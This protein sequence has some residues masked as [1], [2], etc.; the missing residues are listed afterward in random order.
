M[1]KIVLNALL[2]SAVAFTA[3]KNDKSNETQP[4][5]AQEVAMASEEQGTT[6]S[7]DSSATVIEWKGEKPTGSHMGTIK[8]SEGNFT[9]NDSAVLSGNFTIDMNSIEVTDLEGDQKANLEAHLKGTVDEKQ[10]DF[11][12]VK[13]FPTAKFEVTGTSKSEDG[14]T[15]LEGNLT[16]REETK[17]ISFPVSISQ[18]GDMM[19]L[20][21]EEFTIDRTKWN[22]NYGSKSV[23]EGLKDNFVYDDIQLKI[24]LKAKKS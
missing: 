1:K 15:L 23:F 12:N 16:I 6:F 18:E 7:V 9:V 14:K 24:D 2:V 11:F 3:C 4:E 19:T 22:V 17:N 13:K 5:D 10:D 8:V 20:T 21:S